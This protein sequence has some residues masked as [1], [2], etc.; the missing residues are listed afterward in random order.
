M[1]TPLRVL[2]VEDREEDAVLVE[3][4]LRQGG[5]D[6]TSTR[7]ETAEAMRRALTEEQWDVI[8]ADY[9]LPQY[10]GMAAF[11]LY[12]EVGLDVPFILVSGTIG[13][14]IAVSAMKAGVHDYVMKNNL[15]RLAPA[16]QRELREAT[17]RSARRQ[18]EEELKKTERLRMIGQLTASLIHDLKNPLQS[19]L[20]S[21]EL[22][23]AEDI[24]PEQ[25]LKFGDLIERQIQRILSMSDEV[26]DFVKGGVQLALRPVNPAAVAQEVV[27]TYAPVFAKAGIDL[28][29][30]SD[31]ESPPVLTIMADERKI[32]RVLQN[33]IANAKDAMPRGGQVTLRVS[34]AGEQVVIEVSDEGGGI[35]EPIR[36]S[37][38]KP[39]VSYGKKC[40]TGLGLAIVKSIVEAHGGSIRFTMREG[41]GTTFH[42]TLPRFPVG[43]RDD[44]AV[45]VAAVS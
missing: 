43:P 12:Q 16:I 7:V 10:S 37:L 31:P 27:D 2:L 45:L 18:A 20:S 15:A 26:L 30:A 39:L 21:A 28:S 38:F 29:C 34:P 5:F 4:E 41:T 36:D 32:W 25:R 14:E 1:N 40:G 33:M 3:R 11:R 44:K 9:S 42:I 8:I 19:I 35:P 13:E 17:E 6:P 22:L 24:R 23:S